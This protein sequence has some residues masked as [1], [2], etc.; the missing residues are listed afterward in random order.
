MLR[1]ITNW[2]DSPLSFR[3]F[4]PLCLHTRQCDLTSEKMWIGVAECQNVQMIFICILRQDLELMCV[5]FGRSLWTIFFQQKQFIQLWWTGNA[6]RSW[7]FSKKSFSIGENYSIRQIPL[8]C[9]ERELLPNAANFP[10]DKNFACSIGIICFFLAEFHFDERKMHLDVRSDSSAR[11][12]W[13]FLMSV[14][15]VRSPC[16][17]DTSTPMQNASEYSVTGPYVQLPIVVTPRCDGLRMITLHAMYFRW[18][19][20][21]TAYIQTIYITTLTKLNDE[22]IWT[23]NV[24]VC[25]SAIEKIAWKSMSLMYEP[26]VNM[27]KPA[28]GFLLSFFLFVCLFVCL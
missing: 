8:I 16:N 24:C 17:S 14:P 22:R 19:P 1:P 7:L 20:G 13:W 25:V 12:S 15:Y 27:K 10:A 21:R 26:N 18:M 3:I 11:S 5:H 4:F 6:V 23:P 28:T 2:I 9:R